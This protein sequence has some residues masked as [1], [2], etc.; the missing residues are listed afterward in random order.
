MT[1]IRQATRDDAEA[2]SGIVC[3]CYDGFRQTDGWSK[4]LVRALRR[5]RG[6]PDCIRGLIEDEA[7][8]VAHDGP[9]VLGVV[10]VKDNEL[11]KLYVDPDH[12]R[13]GVGRR[14]FTHAEA[15]IR[16]RGFAGMFLGAAVRSSLP[17]YEKMGMRIRQTRR[18]DRGPSIGMTT[19]ILEKA[20]AG[21]QASPADAAPS[22]P[23]PSASVPGGL[24][25]DKSARHGKPRG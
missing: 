18:I 20:L 9:A 13:R 19:T 1:G 4:E 23:T 8:F 22:S 6:S 16:R 25:R 21:E 12:Q 10:S 17:F 5:E 14:L 15:V 11:T 3:R 7:V 2:I 24:R